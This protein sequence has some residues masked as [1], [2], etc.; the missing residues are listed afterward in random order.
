[1][2]AGPLD[3]IERAVADAVTHALPGVVDRLAEIGG[4]RA[5]SVHQVAERLEVSDNTVY[6][7]ISEG[8]LSTVP[9]L[10]PARV[11]AT[12]LDEFLAG[13]R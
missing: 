12:E 7:L 5:Y 2:T 11:A 8:H 1:M 3:A 10:N 6:R 13:K 4:P 9:H